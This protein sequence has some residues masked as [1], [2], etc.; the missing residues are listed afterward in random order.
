MESILSQLN[1]LK[2]SKD[3]FYKYKDEVDI[4][5]LDVLNQKL[6]LIRDKISNNSKSTIHNSFEKIDKKSKFSKSWRISKTVFK[7]KDI[8]L[9]EQYSNEI[10]SLLNKLSPKNFEKIKDNILEYYEKDDVTIEML[11]QLI[12]FTINNIFSYAIMQPFYCPY[13]VKLLKIFDEKFETND[14]IDTKCSEFK[15]VINNSANANNA[16]SNANASSD[17]SSN[18]NASSNTKENKQKT[19]E[20]Q[21]YDDFCDEVKN[22]KTKEGYSQFIGELYNNSMIKY[23]TLEININTF[24]EVLEK[25]IEKDSKSETVEYLIICLSKL[26]LTIAEK[27]D[28]PNSR[29]IVGKF[30]TIQKCD[31]IK[32]LKFKIMDITD[33]Y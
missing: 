31:I 26:F 6:N 29:I 17:A 12:I 23:N 19:N 28:K 4:D 21:E 18:T 1:F 13:Y 16:N 8:G 27:L 24:F 5:L 32:R 2:Y 9:C 22:K 7:K 30:K 3:E 33:K 25:E 15:G 14:I 20:Q 10:N 11:K